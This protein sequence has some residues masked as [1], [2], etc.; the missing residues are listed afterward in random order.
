MASLIETEEVAEAILRQTG[1]RILIKLRFP[2][3]SK[4]ITVNPEDLMTTHKS[5]KRKSHMNITPDLSKC[6]RVQ[7]TDADST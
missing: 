7:A 2:C 5:R 4:L 3:L 6:D 1:L